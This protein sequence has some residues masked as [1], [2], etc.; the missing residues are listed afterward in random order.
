MVRER[1]ARDVELG[2]DVTDDLIPSGCADSNR[3]M[4]RNLGSVPM[5]E[6]MSA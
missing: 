2:R 5:A 3:R 1:G 4:I 6:N